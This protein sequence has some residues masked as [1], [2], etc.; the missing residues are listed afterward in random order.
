MHRRWHH[1]INWPPCLRGTQV[2]STGA[3]STRQGDETARWER[4]TRCAWCFTIRHFSQDEES[5]DVWFFVLSRKYCKVKVMRFIQIFIMM[6]FLGLQSLAQT[7]QPSESKNLLGIATNSDLIIS[8]KKICL[9]ESSFSEV[10]KLMGTPVPDPRIEVGVFRGEY[11]LKNKTFKSNS[12]P[13]KDFNRIPFVDQAKKLN[14]SIFGAKEYI[15]ENYSVKIPFDDLVR[16]V[17]M[18]RPQVGDFLTR[19]V[20]GSSSA[21]RQK[22][23]IQLGGFYVSIEGVQSF[24]AFD[25]TNTN[26]NTNLREKMPDGSLI[27]EK[28]WPT[29]AS[30]LDSRRNIISKGHIQVGH[31]EPALKC[32]SSSFI[33]YSAEVVP[34]ESSA[35]PMSRPAKKKNGQQ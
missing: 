8:F 34:R 27:A 16:S 20:E 3:Q 28:L 19:F 15:F 2:D 6:T 29:V 7:E 26:I 33:E 32:G 22:E 17:D 23:L 18:G 21:A 10:K 14:K 24:V 11:D 9:K 12:K 30:M 31:L 1:P 13:L 25:G 5:G 4:F 35:S